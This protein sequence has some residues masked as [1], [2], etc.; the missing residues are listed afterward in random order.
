MDSSSGEISSLILKPF[1][2][3]RS[4][5]RCHFPVLFFGMAPTGPMWIPGATKTR[6][7]PHFDLVTILL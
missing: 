7:F 5:I 4:T 3:E 2:E 6:V 1:A